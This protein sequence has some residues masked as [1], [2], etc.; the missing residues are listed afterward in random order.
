VLKVHHMRVPTD[1]ATLAVFDPQRLRHRV[2]NSCDWWSIPADE[3]QEINAGNLFSV[4]LGRDGVYRVSVHLDDARPDS[5][6]VSGLIR[7]ESGEIFIGAGEQIPGGGLEPDLALGG[8]SL[9]AAAGTYRV[10]VGRRSE[11]ELDVWLEETDAEARNE[12][13][14]SPRLEG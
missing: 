7:C 4:D 9:G 6:T 2:A 13:G 8:L 10:W 14:H 1:T 12:F 11:F 3:V 5:A